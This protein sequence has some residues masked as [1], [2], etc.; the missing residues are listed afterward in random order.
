MKKLTII[1]HVLAKPNT[2]DVVKA[3]LKKLV[4]TSRADKG[5]ISYDLH[6]DNENPAHFLLYENWLSRDLW[7]EHMNNEYL[8]EYID[9]VEGAVES[10]SIH[11]MTH[12]V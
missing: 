5:C 10:F 2:I 12:I 1:T 9:A 3:E 4:S 11:E 6:Q 7:Q 8:K